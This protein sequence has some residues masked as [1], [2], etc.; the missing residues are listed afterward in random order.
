MVAVIGDSAN[1]GSIGVHRACG[2]EPTGLLRSSGWKF[3]RWLDVVMM[4]R[5]LGL[6]DEAAPAAE[7]TP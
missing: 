5:S 6:G 2:F 1:L 7:A 3:D 4:Q